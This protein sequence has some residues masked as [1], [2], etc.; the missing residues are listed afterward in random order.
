MHLVSSIL[1][2]GAILSTALAEAAVPEIIPGTEPYCRPFPLKPF[3]SRPHISSIPL[4]CTALPQCL[5]TLPEIVFFCND[6]LAPPSRRTQT[7]TEVSTDYTFTT[8]FTDTTITTF[9]CSTTV[10]GFTGLMPRETGAMRPRPKTQAAR[11]DIPV[12][13][14][15]GLDLGDITKVCKCVTPAPAAGT[16][17]TT[18]TTT[19]T[20]V[21]TV[22]Y[23]F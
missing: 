21:I 3:I 14:F 23:P 10:D 20:S 4:F 5:L 17:T 6:I 15:D 11:S 16:V 1:A 2:L 19:T 9:R 7:V 8:I 22:R 13:W 12:I 18:T